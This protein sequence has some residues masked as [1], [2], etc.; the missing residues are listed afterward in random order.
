MSSR[1]NFVDPVHL[2]ALVR[3]AQESGDVGEDLVSQ[4]AKIADGQFDNFR[5][6]RGNSYVKMDREDAIQEA[7]IECWEAMARWDSGPEGGSAFAY[8][9][10]VVWN[11]YARLNDHCRRQK[12][13]P[14]SSIVDVD[15]L[16]GTEK[17]PATCERMRYLTRVPKGKR[18]WRK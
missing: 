17:E 18:I 16:I 2:E 4:F 13:D 6:H 12:R 15:S 9:Y 10:K 7:T 1:G 8:F 14:K 5:T 11:C 3:K